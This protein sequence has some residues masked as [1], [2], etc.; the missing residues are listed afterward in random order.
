[1]PEIPSTGLVSRYFRDGKQES[2]AYR[3]ITALKVLWVEAKI[4][5]S[6]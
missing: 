5:C 2:T 4:T 6:L 3:E 1:M